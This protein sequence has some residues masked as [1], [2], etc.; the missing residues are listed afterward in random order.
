MRVFALDFRKLNLCGFAVAKNGGKAVEEGAKVAANTVGASVVT[1]AAGV[2]VLFSNVA[3]FDSKVSFFRLFFDAG[4]GTNGAG[5]GE[6]SNAVELFVFSSFV[7]FFDLI[8]DSP[9]ELTFVLVRRL[10]RAAPLFFVFLPFPKRSLRPLRSN[11]RLGRLKGKLGLAVPAFAFQRPPE[12]EAFSMSANE[13]G[14]VT[15][16]A[17]SA[18][19]T[20]SV[21][22]A[23]VASSASTFLPNFFG[24]FF[25]VCN[26]T[27]LPNFFGN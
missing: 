25:V 8:S 24:F 10:F 1:V 16:I 18:A 9:R 15:T 13:V 2:S 14:V 7:C 5:V 21:V 4:V 17:D 11:L 23:V 6:N 3:V 27:L 20:S 19:T 26:C 22:A 12:T